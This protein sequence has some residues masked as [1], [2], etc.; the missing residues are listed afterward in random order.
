MF[1]QFTLLYEFENTFT[2]EQLLPNSYTHLK[3]HM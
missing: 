1:F 3:E 2:K